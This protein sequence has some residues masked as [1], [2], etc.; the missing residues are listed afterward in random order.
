MQ[1]EKSE[2]ESKRLHGVRVGLFP[3]QSR[4][5]TRLAS[6]ARTTSLAAAAALL[7]KQKPMA[8]VFV[9]WWPGGRIRL[10][11]LLHSPRSTARHASIV[12]PAAS[13]AAVAVPSL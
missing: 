9:A 6:P 13:L 12:Q 8:S 10:N 5:S 7:K 11:A 2:R 4:I 1:R 3:Y